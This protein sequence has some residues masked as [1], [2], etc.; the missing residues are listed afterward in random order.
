MSRQQ[1]GAGKCEM[2]G[3]G[4]RFAALTSHIREAT[5]DWIYSWR[6]QRSFRHSW[7]AFRPADAIRQ[8]SKLPVQVGT[9]FAVGPWH[10]LP[11]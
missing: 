9:R 6:A 4:P 8:S 2:A 10:A 11:R 3:A 1:R 7:P 5:P